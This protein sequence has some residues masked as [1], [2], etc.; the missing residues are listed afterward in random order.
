MKHEEIEKLAQQEY[1]DIIPSHNE[2][3]RQA[4]QNGFIKGFEK[5]QEIHK[6]ETDWLGWIIGVL[7]G[8]MILEFYELVVKCAPIFKYYCK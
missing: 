1:A 8:L 3:A 2:P 4:A 7:T 5:A 6:K